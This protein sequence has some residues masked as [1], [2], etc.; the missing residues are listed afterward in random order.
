MA[1]ATA[2][3]DVI[4]GG[5]LILVSDSEALRDSPA[6]HKHHRL[7]RSLLH[8]GFIREMKPDAAERRRLAALLRA[9][10]TQRLRADERELIWKFRYTLT[11]QPHALTRVLKCVD[12]TD[13]REVAHAR[14]LIDQWSPA[15][16][17]DLIELLSATFVSASPWLRAF[18]VTALRTRATDAQ[19]LAYLLPLV[20]AVQYER[21]V[22]LPPSEAPL[23]A[24]LIARAV[25]NATEADGEL[26]VLFHWYL[27]VE[28]RDARHGMHYA[29]VHDTFLSRLA[30]LPDAA[31][32]H[33]TLRRQERLV[34]VLSATAQALKT[35]GESRPKRI[36]KLQSMLASSDSP[37]SAARMQAEPVRLPLD[38]SVTA[39]ATA[40]AKCTVFK[41]ALSPLGIA[42]ERCAATAVASTPIA[43]DRDEARPAEA[44]SS[45][46]GAG[47]LG[48]AEKRQPASTSA[49]AAA[50]WAATKTA[51]ARQW[52]AH[53]LGGGGSSAAAAASGVEG[54]AGGAGGGGAGGEWGDGAGAGGTGGGAGPAPAVA[55]A[56]QPA[57][58]RTVSYEGGA[59]PSAQTTPPAMYSLI[60]KSGDDM[61]QAC[62]FALP[63]CMLSRCQACL[64]GHRTNWWW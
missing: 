26:A 24:L 63:P 21:H 22:P 59:A 3:G 10:P 19:L 5:A 34:S 45:E 16:V 30:E 25:A 28:R 11:S 18:A 7:A 20:Q 37:L 62:A 2:G 42:F 32:L 27:N 57:I 4:N 36:A 29:Q 40:P 60:F 44:R 51:A 52:C 15:P 17:D 56:A 55:E 38:P 13:T 49:E 61:R 46:A 41:S 6:L 64:D 43:E 23:A 48:A 31:A 50:Q 9:P 12:W 33:I 54:D 58:S 1:S 47:P 35:S 8:V 53:A 14:S 39:C